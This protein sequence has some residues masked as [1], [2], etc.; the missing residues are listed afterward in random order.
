MSSFLLHRSGINS[1]P[2]I[3]WSCHFRYNNLAESTFVQRG[4]PH[5]FLSKPSEQLLT[6][7]FPTREQVRHV[8]A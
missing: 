5:S 8:F 3:R 2:S 1:T 6:P 4:Y 7:D